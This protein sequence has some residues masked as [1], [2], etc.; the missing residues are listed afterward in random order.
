MAADNMS[1][2]CCS[3]LCCSAFLSSSRNCL[4]RSS[5][6]CICTTSFL[7]LCLSA[8]PCLSSVRRN[9][10]AVTSLLFFFPNTS[11]FDF[12]SRSISSCFRASRIRRSSTAM[13]LRS[14]KATVNSVP[15]ISRQRMSSDC[16]RAH[17]SRILARSFSSRFRFSMLA[18]ISSGPRAAGTM[19]SSSSFPRS[20][21][22]RASF[23]FSQ[24]W[25]SL[26][27]SSTERLAAGNCVN[28]KS[29]AS[30]ITP[31]AGCLDCGGR[32]AEQVIAV[33]FLVTCARF[34]SV[35]FRRTVSSRSALCASCSPSASSSTSSSKTASRTSLETR[36]RR[37]IPSQARRR[38]DRSSNRELPRSSSSFRSSSVIFL[39]APNI[40]LLPPPPP[41]PEVGSPTAKLANC[42]ILSRTMLMPRSSEAFNSSTRRR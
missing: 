27:Q 42:L 2:S 19:N 18:T 8:A 32:S 35:R 6:S 39:V 5:S 17:S 29:F 30:D 21:S 1:I 40:P 24:S 11:Y 12:D 9:V 16:I 37:P 26:S 3:I 15:Y 28:A 41:P 22:L 31:D 38:L 34:D 36:R 4:E 23:L 14:A 13:A 20:V 33:N 25:C 10:L 7:I